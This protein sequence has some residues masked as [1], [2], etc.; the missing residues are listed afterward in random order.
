MSHSVSPQ[1]PDSKA[2]AGKP[3]SKVIEIED[4]NFE[5]QVL[6]SPVPV[7]V[8]FTA[9]W[10]APCR[11]IAPPVEALATA[12]FGRVR[13]GKC[14]ADQNQASTARFDIRSLPTLLL[15]KDG[16]VVSQLIGAAPRAKIEAL[17]KS[18]LPPA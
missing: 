11:A 8:D 10:C 9:A 6:R 15:F 13:I 17:V 16:M 4:S 2:D 7:L 12:Y 3:D 1:I 5:Q 14:D 18:A